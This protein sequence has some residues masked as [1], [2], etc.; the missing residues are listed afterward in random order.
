[1]TFFSGD[2]R[3]SLEGQ[4]KYTERRR[5]KTLLYKKKTPKHLTSDL[6]KREKFS[7]KKVEQISW[8][9]TKMLPFSWYF[10]PRGGYGENS[11]QWTFI[12]QLFH[13]FHRVATDVSGYFCAKYVFKQRKLERRK[14][15]SLLVVP[16]VQPLF[17]WI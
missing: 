11:L 2:F 9:V 13:L 4:E 10:E 12:L 6:R 8:G 5:K 17:V 16:T 3:F 14:S 7:S 1:M 15:C